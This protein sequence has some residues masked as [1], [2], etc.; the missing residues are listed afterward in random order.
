[1]GRIN[2]ENHVLIK[3]WRVYEKMNVTGGMFK[4]EKKRGNC[5]KH[6]TFVVGSCAHF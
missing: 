2:F 3:K 6:F 5:Q 4:D 1:M